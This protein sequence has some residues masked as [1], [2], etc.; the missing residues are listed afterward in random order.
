MGVADGGID[1]GE[2]EIQGQGIEE[3]HVDGRDAVA[4]TVGILAKMR[5]TGAMKLVFDASMP[6]NADG[7]VGG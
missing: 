2:Q 4:D 6:A 3:G 1:V 7:E 5:I